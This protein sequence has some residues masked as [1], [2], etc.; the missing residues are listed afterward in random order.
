MLVILLGIVIEVSP[1]C[2]ANANDS[3]LVMFSGI[4][5]FL[6][7]TINLLFFVSIIAL[8]L[9]LE[10]YLEFP[11]STM[12]EVNP[13]QPSKT[14]LPIVLTLAGIVIAVSPVQLK[15]AADSIAVTVL[16]IFVFIQ[17]TNNLWL[18][19]LIIALQLS[20]ESYLGFP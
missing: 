8:Q 5:V 11:S 12:I 9:S 4:F 16:G 6:Q 13:L 18:E 1:V 14:L 10:S 17:P 19:V 20:L 3:I 15:K 7:P 2:P